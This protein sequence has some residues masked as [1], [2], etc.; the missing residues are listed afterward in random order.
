MHPH[1]VALAIVIAA[2]VIVGI[3]LTGFLMIV[4]DDDE[5]PTADNEV[6][7]SEAIEEESTQ[8]EATY[9]ECGESSPGIELRDD[10]LTL[11]ISRAGAQE[12][13]LA[14]WDEVACVLY[15]IDLP[16]Y[17]ESHID[18]T[19]AIDGRQEAEFDNFQL[20]WNYH[21]DNGLSMTITDTSG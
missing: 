16:A 5:T 13:L 6:N 3:G 12:D 15:S 17:I 9:A 19:R 14:E 20:G 7:A 18:Q 1:N 8:L 2:F 11:T 21:P 4:G 10:G